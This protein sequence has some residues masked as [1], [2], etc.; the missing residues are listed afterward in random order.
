MLGLTAALRKLIACPTSRSRA[1][2]WDQ[3]DSTVGGQTVKRPGAADAAV[4]K[5]EG[6]TP[7]AR[8][9]HRLH[10]ALLLP[11]IPRLAARRRWP[12]HGAT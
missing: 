11:P 8:A 9:D 1:W 3:Y 5:L 10:A 4:V 6:H 7:R 12:R 2:V